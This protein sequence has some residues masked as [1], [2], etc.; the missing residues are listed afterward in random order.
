MPSWST[1]LPAKEK[2][3]LILTFETASSE[4]GSVKLCELVMLRGM[5]R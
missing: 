5:C 2:G 4:P 3:G 1:A